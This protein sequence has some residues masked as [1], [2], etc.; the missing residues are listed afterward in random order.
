MMITIRAFA[1]SAVAAQAAEVL[2]IL[3]QLSI[4]KYVCVRVVRVGRVVVLRP[5]PSPC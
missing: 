2:A 4:T 1:V 5:V 3:Q